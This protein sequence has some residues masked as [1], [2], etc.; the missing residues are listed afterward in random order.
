MQSTGG[1]G[2]EI[3]TQINLSPKPI[4]LLLDSVCHWA[5]ALSHAPAHLSH[6]PLS[7]FHPPAELAALAP[8]T[9]GLASQTAELGP[10]GPEEAQPRPSQQLQVPQEL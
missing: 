7:A 6:Q 8:C 2:A 10:G 4:L 9:L 1:I 3:R 5:P